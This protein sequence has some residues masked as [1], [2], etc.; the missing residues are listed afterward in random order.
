MPSRTVLYVAVG[1]ENS[2]AVYDLDARNGSLTKLGDTPCPAPF[3]LT[4]DPSNRYLYAVSMDAGNE[5]HSFSINAATGTLSHINTVPPADPGGFPAPSADACAIATDKTGKFLL[6]AHYSGGFV[7][8]HSLGYNGAISAQPVQCATTTTGCH[9]VKTGASN[10]VAYAPCVAAGDQSAGE[11]NRI[12]QF[13]FDATSG[14]P[15]TAPAGEVTPVDAVNTIT[16]GKNQYGNRGEPGPR[17]ITFHPTASILYAVDE[18]GN[19]VTAY[20]VGPDGS[21]SHTQQL[22]TLPGADTPWSPNAHGADS[23]TSELSI[24]GSGR[25]MY[26]GNRHQQGHAE[27]RHSLGCF[28]VDATDG[29]VSS[30]PPAI[31]KHPAQSLCIDPAGGLVCS[32]GTEGEVGM[33][34]VLK[35]DRSTAGLETVAVHEMGATHAVW[36]IELPAAAAL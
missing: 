11:G 21:L 5:L 10:T 34:S 24:D 4:T 23:A 30:A 9:S 13:S 7:S 19:T 27:V 28:L 26:A 15:F 12:F 36:A 16:D 17:H 20:E 2:I 22:P 3:Q 33:V 35:I 8:A 6:T 1:G 32:C 25:F 14:A 18:Q 29:S 31:L